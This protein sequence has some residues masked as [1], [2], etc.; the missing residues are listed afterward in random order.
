MGIGEALV[1]LLNEQGIPT[2]LVHTMLCP[3]RSRMNI[4]NESEINAVAQKSKL[5][6]KYN[7]EINSES[8][9]EILNEKLAAAAEK[10]QEVQAA[11]QTRSAKLTAKEKSFFDTPAMRQVERTAASVITRSLLGALGIGAS[12]KRRRSSLW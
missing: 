3:P 10:T 9:Y 2:P 7:R 4:L 5:A 11:Q 1:T 8:A 12:T 6:Q